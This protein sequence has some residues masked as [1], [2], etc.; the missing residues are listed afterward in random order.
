MFWLGCPINGVADGLL[1]GALEGD[2]VQ[3]I[4]SLP[5]STYLYLI[6][7]CELFTK[8]V[9][10]GSQK[11]EYADS[12]INYA[13]AELMAD[14]NKHI[15][16]AL[17][18]TKLEKNTLDSFL[19]NGSHYVEVTYKGVTCYFNREGQNGSYSF[20][21]EST[22]KLPEDFCVN[23]HNK[24]NFK[25]RIAECKTRRAKRLG[26]LYLK[27]VEDVNSEFE[28]RK[29]VLQNKKSEAEKR[30]EKKTRL[31]EITGYPIVIL[32]TQGHRKD[33]RGHYVGESYDIFN[34]VIL[35]GQPS[36]K[37]SSPEYISIG[38]NINTEYKDGERI[39]TGRTYSIRTLDK[40]SADQLKRILDIAMEGKTAL[41]ELVIPE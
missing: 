9:T 5:F 32:K 25:F 20:S 21:G 36:S 28:I 19:K 14:P 3:K 10:T 4:K 33:H 22:F 39:E 12:W 41:T 2:N 8:L 6:A 34:F 17:L 23:T 38:E 24:Y 30:Q 16:N 13:K 11:K 15:K 27:F 29:N 31:E 35:T 7:F 26:T 37:Y 40:L 18:D 1:D